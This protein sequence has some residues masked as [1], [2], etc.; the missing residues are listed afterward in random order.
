MRSIR[1]G[2]ARRGRAGVR[3]RGV[4]RFGRVVA[5][6]A[7]MAVATPA[8]CREA[9]GGG[10]D[11]GTDAERPTPP[12]PCASGDCNLYCRDVGAQN[13]SCHDDDC[14]C[15]SCDVDRCRG[16]CYWWEDGRAADVAECVEAE[17]KACA[18]V[19]CDDTS[20]D[21]VCSAA[22]N[23]EVRPGEVF[24]E[25]HASCEGGRCVCQCDAEACE[26]TCS[27]PGLVGE[28]VGSACECRC[29]DE[30]CAATYCEGAGSCTHHAV[31]P[32][33]EVFSGEQPCACGG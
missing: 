32:V 16:Y 11:G 15:H 9:G 7:L 31:V 22:R 12:R 8:G 33:A 17:E 5:V 21:D 2:G 13:G 30:Y 28:C 27:I 26:A 6:F 24:G 29:D 25:I 1:S 14:V 3:S 19:A 23:Y 4:G 20:C 18:C 10:G